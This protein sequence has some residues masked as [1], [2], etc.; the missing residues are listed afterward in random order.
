M[1]LH[2]TIETES[3]TTREELYFGEDYNYFSL[4]AND[5]SNK[6][7]WHHSFDSNDPDMPV[8]IRHVTKEGVVYLTPYKHSART[9]DQSVYSISEG[10]F[11]WKANGMPFYYE[12]E[13]Y[14][15][16]LLK[17]GSNRHDSITAISK[18][19]TQER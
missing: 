6:Q 4:I 3:N 9:Y 1:N 8:R 13:V 19:D 2:P 11:N 5:K 15:L 17:K 16:N 18:L 14:T 7:I 10:A 12:N